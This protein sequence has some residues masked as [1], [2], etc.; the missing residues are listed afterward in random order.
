MKCFPVGE[1][2]CEYDVIWEESGRRNSFHFY[3]I[4]NMEENVHKPYL[5]LSIVYT[6]LL[7]FFFS[8][9]LPI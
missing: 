9:W 6:L 8:A 7:F 3:K 4:K 1:M 2:K 5:N